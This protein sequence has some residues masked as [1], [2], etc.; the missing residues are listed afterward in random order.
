MFNCFGEKKTN[1]KVESSR[2][3]IVPSERVK[4]FENKL[5]MYKKK[6]PNSKS[7]LIYMLC[8]RESC[9]I[10]IDDEGKIDILY[11]KAVKNRDDWIK[12]TCWSWNN[13]Y[14]RTIR[15]VEN[16]IYLENGEILVMSS[17]I[18]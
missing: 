17:S 5:N 14:N 3:I 7:S 4:Y 8:N 9:D 15:D 10:Y 16:I 11:E 6:I 12:S 2:I 1:V 13:I 18:T